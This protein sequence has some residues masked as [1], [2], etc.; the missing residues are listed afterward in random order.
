M[1]SGIAIRVGP[2]ETTSATAVP[3][4]TFE[5]GFGACARTMPFGFAALRRVIFEPSLASSSWNFADWYAIPVT[6]GT[7]VVAAVGRGAGFASLW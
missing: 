5:P 2:F 3:R 6:L 4:R 1:T 7:V